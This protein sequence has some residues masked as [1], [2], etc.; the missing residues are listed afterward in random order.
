MHIN[1]DFDEPVAIHTDRLDWQ[2]SPMA[3][4][5][6][7]ML[8]RLGDEVARA[9]SIVRYAPGSAFSEHTHSG[10]EEF[11]V[12]EGVFQDEH[13]DYPAGTYV[14]NPIGTHH[15]PRSD[16]GCTIFVELWQFDEADQEQM[17]V[18]LNG[19]D[20]VPD[21]KRPGVSTAVLA[22]RSY[23]EVTLQDWIAGIE[24]NLESEGGAELL[25]LRGS[26][27][28]LGET[29]G[30]HDWIRLPSGRSSEFAAG[31]EGVRVWIKRGHLGAIRIPGN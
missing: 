19:L 17:V 14:R 9:T 21:E 23:E 18:D 26:L 24:V 2:A 27:G 4:V 30:V 10:G 29:F 31:S 16:P 6:R 7:R 22:K 3:G 11:I 5:D 25:I 20:T 1:A 12:L 15:V 8:D 13:G 28:Y